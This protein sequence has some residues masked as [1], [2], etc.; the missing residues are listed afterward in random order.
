M[1]EL[2]QLVDSYD[3]SFRAEMSVGLDEVDDPTSVLARAARLA[4][5]DRDLLDTLL[6]AGDAGEAID[7]RF[8]GYIETHEALW[9]GGFVVPRAR[10]SIGAT[11]DPR[12]Y[13]AAC[14]LSPH[15]RGRRPFAGRLAEDSVA[16]ASFPPGDARFDRVVIAAALEA[17]P[18]NLTR[19]GSPRKDQLDRVL[20]GLG[21]PTRW[22]LALRLARASGMARPAAGRLYGFPESR[23]RRLVDPTVVLDAEARAAGRVLLRLVGE[24]WVSLDGVLELLAERAS[25][26]LVPGGEVHI[27]VAAEAFHRIGVLEG[28]RSA[29]GLVA[30]RKPGE[31][32]ALPPG[33]LLTPD[34]DILVGAGELR[35]S[36]YGRLSRLAPAVEGDRVHRHKLTRAG[37]AAD[38][39]VGNLDPL[40]FLAEH[41]RT[42]VPVSVRQSVEEWLRSAERITLLSGVKIVES[43]D[44]TLRRGSGEGR[45]IDYTEPP[46]AAFH[47]EGDQIVVPVGRDALTVRAALARVGT[48]AGRDKRSWIY[49][50]S[51]GPVDD[52]GGL[53]ETLRRMHVDSVLP[54]ELE[55]RVRAVNG[56]EPVHTESALVVHLPAAICDALRRD[57]VAGPLL[58]R[59]VVH[60]QCLVRAEDLEALRTRLA[61]LG[62]ELLA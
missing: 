22:T 5:E 6:L 44:G 8:A 31:Q 20:T 24:R 58:A 48:L 52:V 37:V 27:R 57:H 53:L 4:D 36:D 1:S 11:I 39:A 60:G 56:V 15:L 62:V 32:P 43:P 40:E 9:L 49:D 2:T 12:F 33:F 3:A 16:T 42:G 28:S 54:G 29:E 59:E 38:M 26:A 35:S 21:D 18:P 46:P 25:G 14:R 13:A 23:P 17:R 55:V 45:V 7:A 34:M 61:D 30:V 19:D 10:P 41:S 51:P 47:M 50:V